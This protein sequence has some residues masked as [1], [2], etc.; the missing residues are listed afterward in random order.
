MV[1]DAGLI[2]EFDS[3]TALLGDPNSAFYAMAVDA[4]LI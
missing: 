2:K 1:M 4:N 3:P